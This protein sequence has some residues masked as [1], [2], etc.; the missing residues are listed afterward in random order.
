[1]TKTLGNGKE[2]PELGSGNCYD[3][4]DGQGDLSYGSQLREK[5]GETRK[6]GYPLLIL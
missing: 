3:E 5:P 1:M 6:Q 2:L 4:L